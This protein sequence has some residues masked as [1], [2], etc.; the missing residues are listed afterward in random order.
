M[1]SQEGE[2]QYF[3]KKTWDWGSPDEQKQ[4]KDDPSGRLTR[5]FSGGE[6]AEGESLPPRGLIPFPQV[7][8]LVPC[9]RIQRFMEAEY[10]ELFPKEIIPG[11][12][13]GR[14]ERETERLISRTEEDWCVTP[15]KYETPQE[16]GADKGALAEPLWGPGE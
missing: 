16:L 15:F 11:I 8:R 4:L 9:A 10:R 2:L 12:V 3:N 1:Q 14:R 7:Y 5:P 6:T 13:R